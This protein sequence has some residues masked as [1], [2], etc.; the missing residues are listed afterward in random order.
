MKNFGTYKVIKS[1]VINSYKI[2]LGFQR[3]TLVT[4]V[5]DTKYEKLDI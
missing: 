1:F 3:L 5:V 2:C 4:F